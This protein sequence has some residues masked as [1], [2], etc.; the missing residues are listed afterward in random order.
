[1]GAAVED[2]VATA[3]AISA[4]SGDVNDATVGEH[5]RALHAQCA[6]KWRRKH[7]DEVPLSGVERDLADVGFRV[8]VGDIGGPLRLHGQPIKSQGK[9]LQ[10]SEGI[11]AAEFVLA[12]AVAFASHLFALIEQFAVLWAVGVCR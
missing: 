6:N 10:F 1:M 2:F 4:A 8:G 12:G 5:A 9:P 3:V 7:A 11:A